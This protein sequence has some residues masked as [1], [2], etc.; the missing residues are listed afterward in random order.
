MKTKMMIC[1]LGTFLVMRVNSFAGNLTEPFMPG[2]FTHADTSYT[3]ADTSCCG[4]TTLFTYTT[5]PSIDAIASYPGGETA[6]HQ[7]FANHLQYPLMA[8]NQGIEGKLFVTITIKKNGEIAEVNMMNEIGGG[9]EEEV[10]RV[11]TAM[12]AW[13]PKKLGGEP[14]DS[15]CILSFNFQL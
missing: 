9:C 5:I 12:P 4:D 7:Y 13:E 14:V 11:L 2:S 3:Q 8:K 1:I 6:L 15:K 10:M